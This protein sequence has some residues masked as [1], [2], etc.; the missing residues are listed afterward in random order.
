MSFFLNSYFYLAPVIVFY[1][2]LNDLS[3][4]ITQ[5]DGSLIIFDV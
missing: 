1:L 5:E 2:E 4:N 3:G